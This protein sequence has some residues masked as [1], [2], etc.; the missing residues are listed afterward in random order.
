MQEFLKATEII[1]W[2]DRSV[3]ELARSLSAGNSDKSEVAKSV[4]N[5]V[6]DNIEH[7]SDYNRAEVTCRASEVLSVGT[8]FC[9]AKSQL[10]AALMRACD[11]PTGFC[12]QRLSIDG[13]GAPF[14]LHGL[15]AVYLEPHGWYR[16]DARGNTDDLQTHFS[17]P[18]EN[19]AFAISLA[20]EHTF[21]AIL[22]DPLRVVVEALKTAKSAAELCQAL[23][24]LQ[25][26]DSSTQES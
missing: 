8:G 25:Q 1:D 9:Y 16:L 19:L 20:E 12:Y 14:C 18:V 24:D 23:P 21:E 2:H 3:S 5:W 7:T 6:R 26:I 15:N 4:F 17:P 10:L 22:P 13:L 11:I